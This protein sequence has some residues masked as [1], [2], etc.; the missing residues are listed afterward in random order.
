MEYRKGD[1]VSHRIFGS[2]VVVGVLPSVA[3]VQFKRLSTVRNI[4][5]DFKGMTKGGAA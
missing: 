2:G 5:A 1:L 4:L 3:V